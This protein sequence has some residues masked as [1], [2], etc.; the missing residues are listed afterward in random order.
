MGMGTRDSS[1]NNQ[2]YVIHHTRYICKTEVSFCFIL[3]M[4]QKWRNSHQRLF[5]FL[6]EIKIVTK[7]NTIE[8]L[9][10]SVDINVDI[11]ARQ[12]KTAHLKHVV[13]RQVSSPWEVTHL[14]DHPDSYIYFGRQG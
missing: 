4:L 8:N 13:S 2:I 14:A 3:F 9:Y 5:F 1:H 6:V 12:N 11:L 10:T 7:K